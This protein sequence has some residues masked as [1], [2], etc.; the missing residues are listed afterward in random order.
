[1]SRT[2]AS[3]KMRKKLI[4]VNNKRG[5]AM[6]VPQTSTPPPSFSYILQQDGFYIL[7][8][9]GFKIVIQ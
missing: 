3:I 8:Q 2:N 1:M 5:I 7:Q 4:Q 9:D 6:L